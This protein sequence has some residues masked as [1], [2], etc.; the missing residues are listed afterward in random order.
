[1]HQDLEPG[2]VIS[3]DTRCTPACFS[4]GTD[5]QGKVDLG[6]RIAA[7][8]LH[9]IWLGEIRMSDAFASGQI[10][11]ET[12]PLRAFALMGKFETVFRYA[13][14]QYPVVLRERGLLT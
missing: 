12:N 14:R 7:D 8:T 4:V 6:L 3:L 9:R 1:M 10:K 13:E 2:R 11:L 5:C